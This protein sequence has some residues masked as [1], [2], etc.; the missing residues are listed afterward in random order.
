VHLA[1]PY[2]SRVP[3]VG[4]VFDRLVLEADATTRIEQS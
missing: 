1:Y 3:V 2:D 4:A